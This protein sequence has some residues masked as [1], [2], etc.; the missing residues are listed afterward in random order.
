[1]MNMTIQYIRLRS[2]TFGSGSIYTNI[3]VYRYM[4]CAGKKVSFWLIGT[5][6]TRWHHIITVTQ[7]CVCVCVMC[8]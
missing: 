6:M 2:V 4:G 5:L 3:I 1:M 7:E 8:V